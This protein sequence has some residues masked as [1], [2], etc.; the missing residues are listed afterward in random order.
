MRRG[1]LAAPSAYLGEAEDRVGEE[2]EAEPPWPNQ[3]WPEDGLLDRMKLGFSQA[4]CGAKFRAPP[5]DGPD[6]ILGFGKGFVRWK[7]PSKRCDTFEYLL[8]STPLLLLGQSQ[9]CSF[10]IV[11]AEV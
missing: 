1:V 7:C 6:H 4:T 8:V 5:A 11:S 10:Q 9:T 3:F 2:I